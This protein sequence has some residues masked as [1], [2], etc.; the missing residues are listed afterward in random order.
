MMDQMDANHSKLYSKRIHAVSV[1]IS[2]SVVIKLKKH[3]ACPL[4]YVKISFECT[5][6]ALGFP[7][8]SEGEEGRHLIFDF[9]RGS[10]GSSRPAITVTA[11]FFY[12][13]N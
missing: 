3:V 9:T 8:H 1:D 6:E 5:K 10:Q 11:L 7:E 12:F 13:M 4:E 2:L